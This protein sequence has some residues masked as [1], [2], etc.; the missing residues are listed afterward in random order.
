MSILSR[1][2]LAV[3]A[4]AAATATARRVLE[5]RPP[6]GAER[7]TRTNHRGEPIALLEGPAVAIGLIGG[8]ASGGLSRTTGALALATGA[9]AVFGVIDDLAEDTSQRSRGLRGHLDAARHGRLTTGGLKV[10][11]IG[12]SGLVCAALLAD[13]DAG[14]ARRSLDVLTD[15]AL[16]AGCANLVNL[17]DLRPGRALKVGALAAAVLGASG[18]VHA[19]SVHGAAVA[20]WPGDLS[21]RDMLGDCGANAL[22][23]LLGAATVATATRG[24]RCAALTVVV[25]LTI[26]SERVSFSRV[27]AETPWLH[28]LDM[29]G[30]RPL[31]APGRAA[32]SGTA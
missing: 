20:A 30:R 6:G 19:P 3:A 9:S 15:G 2:L 14:P 23:A 28:T 17:L 25:A 10:L 27:I 8:L 13:P 12:A 4:A 24:V 7:W 11:G 18:S 16:V 31:D 22:G 32:G 1:Q 29:V 5:R 21:E 26:A